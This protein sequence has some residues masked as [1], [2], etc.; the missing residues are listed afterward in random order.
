MIIRG[1]VYNVTAYIPYHPGGVS[2]LMRGAGLTRP[3]YLV[4]VPGAVV[5]MSL[6]ILF[7]L[8]FDL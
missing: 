2:E 5:H 1:K 7:L 4:R 6:T 3:K 8:F